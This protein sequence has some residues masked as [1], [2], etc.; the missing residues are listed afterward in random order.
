MC[1][2]Y[3]A[4]AGVARG[5]GRDLEADRWTNASGTLG[6]VL[7][8]RFFREDTGLF[9]DTA[10]RSLPPRAATNAAAL[11]WGDVGAVERARLAEALASGACAPPETPLEAALVAE[12]LFE[13]GDPGSALDSLGAF[14]CG[15]AKRGATEFW[16]QFDPASSPAGVPVAERPYEGPSLAY[17][18]GAVAG[19]LV[20]RYVLGIH[21]PGR[22]ADVLLLPGRAPLDRASGAAA[23]PAGEVRLQWKADRGRLEAKGRLPEGTAATLS[24]PLARGL[25]GAPER[26]ELVWGRTVFVDASGR[27]VLPEGIERWNRSE[28]EV[29]LSLAAGAS[30]DVT[31]RP[32]RR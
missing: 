16:E 23:F 19:A 20:L 17:G 6:R 22:E 27:A 21:A 14:F 28:G 11:L 4:A 1:G 25:S 30:F 32:P 2:A 10:T 13:A 7:R 15:M 12:S 31:R 5:L 29:R 26:F 8:A 3:R 18:P 24:I 9:A